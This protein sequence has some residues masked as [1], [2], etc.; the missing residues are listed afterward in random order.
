MPGLNC[1]RTAKVGT[2]L[3]FA[4]QYIFIVDLNLN[5]IKINIV[6]SKFKLN[7]SIFLFGLEEHKYYF[8]L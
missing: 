6:F 2:T 5:A 8:L 7:L 3:Y 1:S 4:F